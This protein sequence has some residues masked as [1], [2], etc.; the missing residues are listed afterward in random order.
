MSFRVTLRQHDQ[1]IPV[2]M[3]ETILQAALAQGIAYP[4][5]CQSGNCGA[6][7]S[8]LLAGEVDLMPY[9]DYAL[10]SEERANGLTRGLVS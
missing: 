3:G 10:T 4:H 8:R 9:S 6:C 1:A 7:K 2:E 5:G